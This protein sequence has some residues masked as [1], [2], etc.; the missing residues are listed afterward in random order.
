VRERRIPREVNTK[1][2]YITRRRKPNKK[3]MQEKSPKEQHIRIPMVKFFQ[4][5]L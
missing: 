5:K 4:I 3:G 2:K 1:E